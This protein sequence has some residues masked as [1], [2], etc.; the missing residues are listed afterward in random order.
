MVE[1]PRGTLGKAKAEEGEPVQGVGG[2]V[3]ASSF[4]VEHLQS[5][6][7][8]EE[9]RVRGEKVKDRGEVTSLRRGRE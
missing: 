4:A 3:V 7:L 6:V 9:D 5:Q 8:E 2:K 1:V